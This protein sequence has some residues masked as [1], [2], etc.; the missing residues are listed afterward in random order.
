MTALVNVLWMALGAL[1][2]LLF[3]ASVTGIGARDARSR[4]MRDDARSLGGR[5]HA[6]AL[7]PAR[8]AAPVDR[9]D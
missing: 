6:S 5:A 9:L 2:L 8:V 7:V 1:V 3:V 4:R